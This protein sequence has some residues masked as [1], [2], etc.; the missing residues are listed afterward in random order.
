MK[1]EKQFPYVIKYKKGRNNIIVDVLYYV[2][3][4]CKRDS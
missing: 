1:F 2:E 3:N 4:P